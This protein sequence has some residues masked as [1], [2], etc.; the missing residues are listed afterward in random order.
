M[1]RPERALLLLLVGGLAGCGATS[2]LL[3]S[4][5]AA[6]TTVPARPTQDV[7]ISRVYLDPLQ[8]LVA[9]SPAVQAE[10]LAGMKAEADITPTTTNRLRYALALSLPGHAGADP[11]AARR[12][13]SELLAR[14]ELLM[15]AE[16]SLTAL[17]LRE[18]EE[19]LVLQAE[20][21]RLQQE[22]A[23]RDR[24]RSQS[25]NRR[26]Q[27]EADEN[28]RLRKELDEARKKLEAVTQLERSITERNKPA[29]KS[30]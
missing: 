23:Q 9:A 15:S 13:L 7:D 1:R 8:E 16:R 25:S 22:S 14:P 30:P 10:L 17:H 5:R 26:L 19:R 11:V 3:G 21:R 24:E 4:H 18:V 28:A 6:P 20:I 2:G 29:P 12:Q 27:A